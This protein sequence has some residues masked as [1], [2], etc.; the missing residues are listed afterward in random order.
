MKPTPLVAFIRY[1]YENDDTNV[2]AFIAELLAKNLT[3]EAEQNAEKA[4]IDELINQ[5]YQGSMTA[6]K[7][8]KK[9]HELATYEEVNQ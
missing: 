2:L 6:P 9:Y 8:L 5:I 3:P 7:N 1:A 4:L